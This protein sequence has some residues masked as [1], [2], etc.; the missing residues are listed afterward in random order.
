MNKTD[1]SEHV[2]TDMA[3]E[4]NEANDAKESYDASTDRMRRSVSMARKW[5]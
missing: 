1:K 2:D 3:Y 5:S 4:A